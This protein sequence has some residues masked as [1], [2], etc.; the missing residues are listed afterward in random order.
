MIR[1][2]TFGKGAFTVKLFMAGFT[3]AAV[4]ADQ[5]S[6]NYDA[7][8]RLVEVSHAGSVNDGLK[9]R[10]AYDQA[11]N[12]SKVV[13][14]WPTKT[15]VDSGAAA[16][17]AFAVDDPVV[18]EGGVLVFTISR[19]GSS[20]ESGTVY[21]G[22]E[23][24]TARAGRDYRAV[25][26]TLTFAPGEKDKTVQISTVSESATTGWKSLSLNLSNGSAHTSIAKP[27]GNGWILDDPAPGNGVSFS[28]ADTSVTEG[29]DL[30]F[31]VAKAG[32]APGSYTVR[33]ATTSGTAIAMEDFYPVSGTLT[34]ADGESAKTVIVHTFSDTVPEQAETLYFNLGETSGGSGLGRVQAVGAILDN[35]RVPPKE[36]TITLSTGVSANLRQLAN[37]NGYRGEANVIYHFIVPSGATIV[38][39]P[40]G[41]TGIDTGLWPSGAD[42]TLEIDGSVLGGGGNGGRGGVGTTNGESGTIGGDAITCQAPMSIT[43]GATGA[44]KGGGGGG[45]GAG[46]SMSGL[47]GGGGGGGAPNGLGG[48]TGGTNAAPGLAGALAG[49][50]HG[51]AGAEGT[52]GGAGGNYAAIGGIG[53]AGA[54]RSALG[55][56]GGAAIGYNRGLCR[57]TGKGQ[58]VGYAG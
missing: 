32:S 2:A 8:G 36:T 15:L 21:Y 4:A 9:T 47:A 39:A 56:T 33:Y 44:L 26:G 5:I 45:G 35:G 13:A 34:F 37:A 18:G 11:G 7:L 38:G 40:G 48:P 58:V 19:S 12:R 6:Y 22:T 24:G 52:P 43:V 30:V 1:R 16:A 57:L 28:V 14:V 29:G 46:A 51:S 53:T 10:Y 54:T 41:G 20:A 25:T 3:C 55:S 17:S 27:R 42:L 50:G 31:T 49:G 23:D